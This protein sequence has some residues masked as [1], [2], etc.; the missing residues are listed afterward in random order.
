MKNFPIVNMLY[1]KTDLR[2]PVKNLSFRK[3]SSSLIFNSSLDITSI[4]ILHHNMKSLL[5]CL[6][7][8][9][10]SNDV[11]MVEIF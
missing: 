2:E 9:N 7:N 5:L 11:W 4:C 10:E 8:L 6:V 1:S 3:G